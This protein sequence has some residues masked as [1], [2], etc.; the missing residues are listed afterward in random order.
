MTESGLTSG[1]KNTVKICP[2]TVL[3]YETTSTVGTAR[4]TVKSAATASTGTLA[5]GD[6][7]ICS[8]KPDGSDTDRFT[9]KSGL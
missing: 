1:G 5:L 4:C 2:G 9:I 7:M 8:N 3:Q 6:K